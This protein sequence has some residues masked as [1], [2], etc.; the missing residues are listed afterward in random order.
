MIEV[1]EW[2]TYPKEDEYPEN[3]AGGL[4]GWVNGEKF[5]E[6]ITQ[7]DTVAHPYLEA[8]RKD[9]I[10]KGLRLTGEQHQHQP[11]G[12]PLFTDGT[13]STFSY[14][15]WGDLM[16]AIWNSEENTDKYRYMDFYM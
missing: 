7:Y 13:V 14:R 5:E 16:A 3:E 15:G 6:Y 8:I 9:V 1:K 4:G 12:V 2:I 11:N 10:A